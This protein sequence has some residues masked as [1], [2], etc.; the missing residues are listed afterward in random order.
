MSNAKASI[1]TFAPSNG[2][3]MSWESSDVACAYSQ[4]ATVFRMTVTTAS[5][6]NATFGLNGWALAANTQFYAYAPYDL[7]HYILQ[8]PFTALTAS[9]A[10]Q[11]QKGNAST[12][13]LT[14]FDYMTAEST[15]TSSALNFDF[16]HLGC[17]LRIAAKMPETKDIASID[18]SAETAIFTTKATM[19]V[20]KGTLTPSVYDKTAS[21]TMSNATVSKGDSLIAYIM[22]APTNAANTPITMR[23]TATDGTASSQIIT[24]DGNFIAGKCHTVSATLTA[25]NE[26][27]NK[28][29]SRTKAFASHP[30]ATPPPAQASGQ[31]IISPTGTTQP[32][33]ISSTK[34]HTAISTTS[35]SAEPKEYR[36]YNLQGILQPSGRSLRKGSIYIING[37]KIK[38]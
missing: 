26:Q 6:T 27:A 33:G 7:Q 10:N 8:E 2:I 24:P 31:G 1:Y 11:E 14:A 4:Q 19:D 35:A 37:K 5:N 16:K 13:H 23:I 38:K 18:L 25:F 17:V 21:L 32:F 29:Q 3:S 9:Y 30:A 34:I 28:P 22:M 36:I 12:A 20:T 15:S